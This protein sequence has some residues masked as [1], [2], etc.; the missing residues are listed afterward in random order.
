MSTNKQ[1]TL[2][3]EVDAP[4]SLVPEV[5]LAIHPLRYFEEIGTFSRFRKPV[6]CGQ[7]HARVK[8]VNRA[9]PF[10]VHNV[11]GARKSLDTSGRSRG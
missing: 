1:N 9:G 2:S 10:E 8:L 6:E 7:W 5:F 4:P 3:E 11:D